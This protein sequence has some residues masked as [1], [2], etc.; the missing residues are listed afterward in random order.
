MISMKQVALNFNLNLK[1][2][3]KNLIIN[4]LPTANDADRLP[5]RPPAL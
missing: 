5:R 3:R 1:K 2:A 4:A